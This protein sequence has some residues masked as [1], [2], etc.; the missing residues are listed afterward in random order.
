MTSL[1]I[2]LVSL[3]FILGYEL[4]LLFLIVCE[5]DLTAAMI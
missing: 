1:S 5:K 2:A 3:C 4:F